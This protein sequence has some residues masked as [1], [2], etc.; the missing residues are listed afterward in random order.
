VISPEC[1]EL[2]EPGNAQ[3]LANSISGLIEAPMRRQAMGNAAAAG[4]RAKFDW[5]V[6]ARRILDVY[7]EVVPATPP[8]LPPVGNSG[9]V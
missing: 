5:P 2:V 1:G 4:V 7:R 9:Q 6:I 8:G 3:A